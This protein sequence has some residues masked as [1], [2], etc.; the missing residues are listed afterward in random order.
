M[1]RDCMIKSP[2]SSKYKLCTLQNEVQVQVQVQSWEILERIYELVPRECHYPKGS[3]GQHDGTRRYPQERPFLQPASVELAHDAS[4]CLYA[5]LESVHV[6]GH[7]EKLLRWQA[8]STNQKS[9]RLAFC[10]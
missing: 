5:L 4:Y 3:P 10:S 9:C 1:I 7:G 6:T 8:C 2:T